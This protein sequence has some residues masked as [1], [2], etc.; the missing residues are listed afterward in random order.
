[1][2]WNVKNIVER[3]VWTFAQSAVG[4]ISV[5][6]ATA[7]VADADIGTLRTIGLTALGAGVAAILSLC[8]NLTAEGIVVESAGRTAAAVLEASPPPLILNPTAGGMVPSGVVV[9][10]DF[11]DKDHVERWLSGIICADIEGSPPKP[12]SRARKAAKPVAK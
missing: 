1:M 2:S 10:K 8:K 5:V 7:A 6:A 3:A 11:D 4:S 12:R 9:P